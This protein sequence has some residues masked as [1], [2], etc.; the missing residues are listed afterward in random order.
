M[1]TILSRFAN[2]LQQH[3][4][5]RENKR[6]VCIMPIWNDRMPT[7]LVI[8]Y[9]STLQPRKLKYN[10]GHRSPPLL[11]VVRWA[12]FLLVYDETAIETT[13]S[14]LLYLSVGCPGKQ[15]HQRYI[16]ISEAK[17]PEPTHIQQ[18]DLFIYFTIRHRA[19]HTS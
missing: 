1:S 2:R 15:H 4:G 3:K 19:L 6:V 10:R 11:F 16:A 12:L 17:F 18:R 8:M 5:S 7:Q 14:R 9:Q 13:T